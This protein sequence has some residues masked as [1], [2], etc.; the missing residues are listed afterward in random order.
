MARAR[1]RLALLASL[2]L[3]GL[4]V[5]GLSRLPNCAPGP[6]VADWPGEGGT[7]GT[8]DDTEPICFLINPALPSKP[9]PASPA[10]SQPTPA[11]APKPQA[12][13]P[14]AASGHTLPVGPTAHPGGGG[15]TG[16][17]TFFNVPASSDAVVYVVDHSASMGLG[18]RLVAAQKELLASLDQL[19]ESA[20]FQVI[21]YNSSARPL[22]LDQPG[23]MQATPANKQRVAAALA[24]LRAE[25]GTRHDSALPKALALRP[26]VIYFLTDADD[27]ADDYRRLVTRLN[28]NHAVIHTI[29]LGTA[30]RG[31]PAMPLQALARDNGGTYQAVEVGAWH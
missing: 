11:V 25:G 26:A 8:E 10:P 19:P 1:W 17:T 12:I 22:L 6:A 5:F 20:R 3:H 30:N 28:S 14:V 27:L 16:G 2:L 24:Q 7:A 9:K 13:T 31:R 23:M 18:G 29:E 15:R 21:V 4:I